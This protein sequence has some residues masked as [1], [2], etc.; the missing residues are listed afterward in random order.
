[1]VEKVSAELIALIAFITIG[2]ILVIW[3]IGQ[4]Q[5]FAF[6][7]GFRLSDVIAGDL[8]GLITAS[9]GM[10]GNI[11]LT[12]VIKGSSNPTATVVDYKF[13]FLNLLICAQS[14]WNVNINTT[15]C[16]I[17]PST[18]FSAPTNKSGNSGE[19]IEF[20]IIKKASEYDLDGNYQKASIQIS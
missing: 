17:I 4:F 19:D 14:I 11:D 13:K 3:L 7:F 5:E 9:S 20:N 2:M 10:P 1:M 15:D 16:Y 12:H 6:F 18:D 8:S